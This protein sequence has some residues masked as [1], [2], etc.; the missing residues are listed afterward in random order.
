M[1]LLLVP[2]I[3]AKARISLVL[4]GNEIRAFAGMTEMAGG[5][6]PTSAS[7]WT[8]ARAGATVSP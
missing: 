7:A 3:L 1:T 6:P 8:P 5:V 4:E 2:V